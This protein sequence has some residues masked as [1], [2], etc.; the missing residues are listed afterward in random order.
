MDIIPLQYS[1]YLPQAWA[2][3]GQPITKRLTNVLAKRGIGQVHARLYLP[4]FEV[5]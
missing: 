3:Y 2:L 4:L 1:P 5:G